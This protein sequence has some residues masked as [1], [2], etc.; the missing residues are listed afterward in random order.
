MLIT[1]STDDELSNE[2]TGRSAGGAPSSSPADDH[3]MPN[4]S[5]GVSSPTI[6]LEPKVFS[7][8]YMPAGKSEA[9]R[10]RRLLSGSS[11]VKHSNQRDN[12]HDH[13]TMDIE[14]RIKNQNLW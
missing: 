3:F 11:M 2:H 1:L 10:A 14:N 4:V 8:L 7:P 6:S 5:S 13:H 12:E 9:K